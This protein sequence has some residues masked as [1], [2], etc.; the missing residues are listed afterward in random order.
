MSTV[1]VEQIEN[2]RTLGEQIISVDYGFDFPVNVI[3]CEGNYVTFAF[4]YYQIPVLSWDSLDDKILHEEYHN[5]CKTFA[6]YVEN[7]LQ[8]Q[9]IFL[10][11][12]AIEEMIIAFCI[13]CFDLNEVVEFVNIEMIKH[14]SVIIFK[15]TTR[16]LHPYK[17]IEQSIS[18]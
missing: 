2:N 1:V 6:Y 18:Y 9:G 12:N 5:K 8:K 14:F 16:S 15:A 7:V 13:E 3:N 10:A 11:Q 17:S 4:D